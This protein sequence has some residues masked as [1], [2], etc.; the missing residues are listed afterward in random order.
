MIINVYHSWGFLL[1]ASYDTDPNM[2]AFS[3]E[4]DHYSYFV[5]HCLNGNY[6]RLIDVD[7]FYEKNLYILENDLGR[8][9]L[10]IYKQIIEKIYI[11]KKYAS[12]SPEHKYHAFM[13]S[14]GIYPVQSKDRLSSLHA[15]LLHLPSIT[16]L[17]VF[18]PN[19]WMMMSDNILYV[20]ISMKLGPRITAMPYLMQ[21]A[22]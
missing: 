18:H 11:D 7:D 6:D 19:T 4:A 10:D 17:P 22:K 5:V 20:M 3:C 1:Q 15:D 8:L 14:Q 2:V 16:R 9:E 21:F 13:I 12:L